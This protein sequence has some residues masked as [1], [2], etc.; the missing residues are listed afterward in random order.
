M[1]GKLSVNEGMVAENA[2]AQAF[3]MNGLELFFYSRPDRGDG[4]GRMEVDFLVRKGD[5]IYPVEVKSGA[6]QHHA[7]LDKFRRKF[8]NRLGDAYILYTKDLMVKDGI[9]HLPLYMSM[10]L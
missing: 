5:L 2:V 9:R 4:E 3:R 7:S 1:L 8:K 10:F 6:Y